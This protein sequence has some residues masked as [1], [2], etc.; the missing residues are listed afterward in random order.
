MNLT[1]YVLQIP[2]ALGNG[3]SP[4]LRNFFLTLG[5]KWQDIAEYLGFSAEE[6]QGIITPHPD[7]SEM[8]VKH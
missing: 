4:E 7:N 5:D 2:T 8:Q 3:T 6:I 1:S